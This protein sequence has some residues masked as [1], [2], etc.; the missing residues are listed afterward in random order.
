MQNNQ[1]NH[2]IYAFDGD[3]IGKRHAKEIL[4]DNIEGIHNISAEITAANEMVRDFVEKNGGQMISFGGDEGV[5]SAPPEFVD[6]LETLRKNYE[7][8]IG[9]TLSIGY[10][11]KPSEAGKALLE[12]KETGK[13]KVVQYSEKSEQHAQNVQNKRDAEQSIQTQPDDVERKKIDDVLSSDQ[14]QYDPS[15]LERESQSNDADE[16]VGHDQVLP[17]GKDSEINEPVISEPPKEDNNHGYDSGYKNSDP[18]QRRDSYQ[19]QDLTSPTISKPNLTPKPKVKEAV[20]GDVPESSRLMNEELP[21]PKDKEPQ[22]KK[23]GPTNYHGQAEGVASA[24]LNEIPEKEAPKSMAQPQD[25]KPSDLKYNDGE[26]SP[27]QPDM[28]MENATSDEAEQREEEDMSGESKHC[29]SCTCGEHDGELNGL[30]DQHL[31]NAR[32]FE[33]S[34][35]DGQPKSTEELLDAHINNQKELMDTIDQ[36]GVMRPADYNEKQGDMGLSEEEADGDQ[37][38][39]DEVLKEGLDVHSDNIQKEKV[40]QLVGQALEGFKSQKNI[41]DK[42]KEQAPDLYGACIDMLRAMIELCSLA[43]LDNSGEAEQE[44]NEIEGQ[45]EA[46]EEKPGSEEMPKEAAPKEGSPKPPQQ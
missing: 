6:L 38:R 27:P 25:E 17:S 11:T 21:D 30:L 23:P 29:A 12:A 44:V 1:N 16:G 42:A 15:S 39:L 46:P 40:I 10:G 37:P 36:T 26:Q 33:Q 45:S 24:M 22:D 20:T 32:D 4:S 2:L 5:F 28:P 35:D 7:R 9:A 41:L 43:G 14:H 8:M 18:Q 13:N 3:E 34:I 31:E 19:A